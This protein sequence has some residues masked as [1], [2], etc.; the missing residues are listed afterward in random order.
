LS[1]VL[2]SLVGGGTR[3]VAVAEGLGAVGLK[4]AFEA[5]DLSSG[6]AACECGLVGGES[7]LKEDLA[8]LVALDLVQ[9]KCHL[10]IGH[11]RPPCG[12]EAVRYV[13][14]VT[15]SLWRNILEGIVLTGRIE[16]VQF[17]RLEITH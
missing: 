4:A 10:R 13:A 14:G 2:G 11:G 7:S 17:E 8:G 6:E 16:P 9:G 1:D 15:F 3:G 5:L 12:Q